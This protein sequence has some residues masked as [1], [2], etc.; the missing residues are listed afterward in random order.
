MENMETYVENMEAYVENVGNYVESF[1]TPA[2]I[3]SIVIIAFTALLLFLN[4]RRAHPYKKGDAREGERANALRLI[5]D[6]L[7]AAIVIVAIIV[8]LKINGVNVVSLV[9]G[10]GIVSAVLGLAMQDTIKDIISG[11][12]VVLYHFYSVGECVEYQGREGT[13]LG[14]NLRTTKIGDLEDHSIRTVCNR[15]ILEI[16]RIAKRMDIDVPLS[17]KENPQ[18]VRAVLRKICE[19]ILN[20]A[21]AVTQCDFLGTQSFESSS[22]LYRIRIFCEPKDRPDVRRAALGIIQDELEAVGIS[23]PFNQLDVH[24]DSPSG[25][26][27]SCPIEYSLGGKPHEHS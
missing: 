24:L 4:R 14:I 18:N 1:F 11:L 8:I 6:L 16:R 25:E 19:Q 10:L 5:H 13:I 26:T 23:I 7:R 20:K 15:N 17:Y 21:E 12:Y 2:V 3:A 22:I 9:T 27:T